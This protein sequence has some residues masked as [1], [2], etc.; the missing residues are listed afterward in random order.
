[1]T[2]TWSLVEMKKMLHQDMVPHLEEM[3]MVSHLE[4]METMLHQDMVPHLEEMNMVPHQE[5]M[6]TMLVLKLEHHLV[7]ASSDGV[8]IHQD[9]QAHQHQVSHQ[10]SLHHPA[11]SILESNLEMTETAMLLEALQVV[12]T[13]AM[14][15]M[16][17]MHS[18]TLCGVAAG[19]CCNHRHLQHHLRAQPRTSWNV[20]TG[21]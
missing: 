5:E 1:M 8:C 2:T 9:H 19:L 17:T 11:P 13:E 6:E 10:V 4:E 3:N 20:A 16:R 14:R 15:T 18:T 21:R 12:A 7:H